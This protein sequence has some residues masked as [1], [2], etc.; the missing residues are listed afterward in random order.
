[1][2]VKSTTVDIEGAAQLMNIHART[3]EK[4]IARG[5]LPA[6]RIGRAYV[7]MERD[8]LAYIEEQI[9]SQTAKKR[10]KGARQ[11]RGRAAVADGMEALR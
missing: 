11:R 7:L 9:T 3:A 2:P 5:I 10:E 8:V 6:A 1:M 4:M